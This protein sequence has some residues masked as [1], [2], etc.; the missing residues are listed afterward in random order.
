MKIDVVVVHAADAE[1]PDYAFRTSSRDDAGMQAV[2]LGHT[3]SEGVLG[4]E[5]A[6]Q[7]AVRHRQDAAV[8][9]HAVDVERYRPDPAKLLVGDSLHRLGLGSVAVHKA[10][11]VECALGLLLL[12]GD[13]AELRLVLVDIVRQSIEQAQENLRLYKDYYRVGTCTMSD[14]LEAQLLF[15]Q[16]MDRATEAYATYRTAV[17]AYRLALGR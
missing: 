14:L 9:H 3:H 17:T 1:T 15:Q 16:T 2:H 7:I 11:Q 8:G 6:E 5:D 13:G 4:V 10:S 12:E